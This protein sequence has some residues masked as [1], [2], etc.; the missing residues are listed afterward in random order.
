MM[1]MLDY[2][3]SSTHSLFQL[4]NEDGS[5]T[6]STSLKNETGYE[7]SSFT[8]STSLK[9]ETCHQHS[10]FPMSSSLKNETN[11]TL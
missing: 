8:V 10:S 2:V 9:N 1:T 7:D 3:F 4:H 11:P 5:F 6:V